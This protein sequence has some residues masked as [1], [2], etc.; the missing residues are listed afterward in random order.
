MPDLDTIRATLA[1]IPS[2][3]A[4]LESLFAIAPVGFQIYEASGRSVMVNQA[5]L[6]LFGAEPPPGY[7]VLQDEIAEKNGVLDLI[8]RAFGGETIH[9]P[10]IWCDPRDLTQVKVENGRR[11]AMSSTFFP[12]CDGAGAVT[13]VAIAFKDM[14][15]EMEQREQM[16]QEHEQA[17][18]SRDRLVGILGHELRTPLTAIIASAA[19]IL[20]QQGDDE[21]V[22][23]AATRIASGAERMSRMISDLLDFAQARLGGGF[24]VQRRPC[25]LGAVAQ[26]VA[27]EIAAA[28]PDRTIALEVKGDVNGT[29][30]ADR[31]AQALSNLIQNA[32]TYGSADQ[33]IGVQVA[34]VNGAVEVAVESGGPAIPDAERAVLFD[35]FRRGS[36]APPGRALGLGLF[37]V[38]QIARAHGGDAE[39]ESA[40]GRNVFRARL[41]R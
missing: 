13:H 39:V 7:N 17:A 3:V 31:A 37:I 34:A 33:R 22:R 24:T 23:S 41:Q 1:R 29:F 14:T 11:A 35:P 26:A 18:H 40:E 8:R 36:A 25:D 4:V 16:E 5:F 15:A 2:P 20:R 21:T 38:Q 27:E 32:I 28:H 30:D 12:L 6:D 10:A 9:I 19:L